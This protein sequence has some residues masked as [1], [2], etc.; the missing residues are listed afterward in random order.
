MVQEQCASELIDTEGPKFRRLDDVYR[1]LEWRLCRSPQD[2]LSRG[3]GFFVYKQ[4]G[5]PSLKD[6]TLTAVYKHTADEVTIIA[7]RIV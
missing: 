2:G 4:D 1:A 6:P 5:I 7:L 3:D